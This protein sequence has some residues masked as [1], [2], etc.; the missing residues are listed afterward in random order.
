M[1]G[2]LQPVTVSVE[3]NHE[4]EPD[5]E[6]VLKCVGRI[7]KR[8]YLTNENPR[9]I[10]KECLELLSSESAMQMPRMNALTQRIIRIRKKKIAHGPNPT[11]RAE[12]D[13]PEALKKTIRN[14]LFFI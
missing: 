1:I 12:I 2:F 14:A 6:E 3:H 13:I 10:I 5:K 7:I 11:T 8:A 4:P 9:T